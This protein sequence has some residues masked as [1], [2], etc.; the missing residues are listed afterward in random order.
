MLSSTASL[1]SL[2]GLLNAGLDSLTS[3]LDF[4][5][6]L[7]Q[8]GRM[9]QVETALPS[10][11]LIPE[12]L[13]MR[14]AVSQ[15]FELALD[16]LSTSAHFELKG[17]IGEQISVRLLQPDGSYRPWHGYVVQA[18]QMGSDGG[19]A[20][21][22]LV[23]RPWLSLLAYRSDCFVYQDKD[24]RQIIDEVFHD[25][26]QTNV[27]WEVT[28]SLRMRS[29]CTQY[30]ESDLAFVQR[31]L[32]EEGL[33]YHFEHLDDEAA[34]AAD[35]R[36]ARHVL[37]ITDRLAAR[38]ALGD[39]RFASQHASANLLG[40]RDA[41]T[42]FSAARDLSANAVTVGSWNYRQLSGT[43]AS[44]DSGLSLGELPRLEVYDGSGAYRYENAA[45][46]DR[47]ASLALAALELDIKRFE[48]QGS[49]RHFAAGARFNLIDHP[50]YGANT[51][52]FNYA[53][54]LTASH[55]RPDNE[56]TLV[57]VE[58]HASNNLGAELSKVLG[59][60]ELEHGTYKNQFQAVPA[61][62]PLVPRFVRK[63]TA[64]G[65]QQ[66]LVVGVPGEAITTE[67]DHRVKIQFAWQRGLN[68]LAGGMAHESAAD[69]TGNAP[70]DDRSGTWVRVAVPG[71]GPN[72][73][74]VLV[75]RI[76]TEVVVEFIEGDIDRPLIIGQLYNGQDL[77]PFS[78]GEDSGVNHPGV[79]SGMQ[80]QSLDGSG[81]NQ[82]AIDD[83]TGQLRMRLLTSYTAAEVGLGHLIQQGQGAQRG[84]WRGS[85][86]E[87]G[88]QGWASVRAGQGLLVSTTARAATYGSAQST[89]MD[90]AEALG[91]LKA[92][93]D[94]GQRLSEVAKAGT[95]HALTS[96]EAG[97]AVE[98]FLEAIDPQKL[99]K[100]AGSVNGQ[101]AK[102]AQGRTLTDP[103][104]A[105]A[106]PLVLMD[107]PSTSA[108]ASEA[109]ITNYSGQ[110]LSL[111]VQGDVQHTAVHTYAA[112]SGQTTSVYT[113]DGG[114]Q[115]KAAN[116]AVSLR[117][118]TDELHILA[119]QDVT[120]ISMEDE[121]RIQAN[122]CI[123]LIAGESSVVLEGG[124]ITFTCPG[125]FTAKTSTHAFLGGASFGAELPVLPQGVRDIPTW[126][127]INHRDA[128]G[129]PMQGQG[130]K[131]FFEGNQVISGTLDAKGHARHDNVP[132]RALRVEYEPR[133]A[134][135]ERPWQPLSELLA[136]AKTR[137][138]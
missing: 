93:R 92:M 35:G 63:P 13:V 135:P 118:H 40:Q 30:R 125:T 28:E 99:G 72:W 51:S 123:E 57:S 5:K 136:A 8:H 4:A 114:I 50:L 19:L 62:A 12:R 29:L 53:G 3:R 34:S 97:Q 138:N 94:L 6:L 129:L 33:S 130:Y 37:V 26:A 124:D 107:T 55:D 131:I 77:P 46:A 54:A 119:D 10:L 91:Q 96:H 86:F 111:G 83:A 15:P 79:I 16:A 17:L 42:A 69:A 44:V 98:K 36:Q 84:G 132:E 11:A 75:P 49:T 100:H 38:P 134:N 126:I 61:A 22:R 1:P 23:M 112:V 56:F 59:L 122:T 41:V 74:A 137:L 88:T 64:F 68:P 87:A 113:N 89:Q 127:E 52:A 106:V 32:A 67:R 103:V 108:F 47:A 82:W 20:R 109:S 21:Y 66:A 39:A 71:A 65:V 115:A 121:I 120:V 25:H 117:A 85:G 70:G 58:H 128:E 76:G 43:S 27:R 2:S 81:F 73:G 105:F 48:G 90:A 14:E 133:Q 80:T 31:L 60:T 104:E 45:H 24:A 102:K 7:D 18:S 95:A 110:D 116:G 101:E 9:L 78:A